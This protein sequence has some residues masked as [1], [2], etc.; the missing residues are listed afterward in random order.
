M[1]SSLGQAT[2][3]LHATWHGQKIEKKNGKKSRKIRGKI[4]EEKGRI[5][6]GL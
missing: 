3:I 1:G 6:L 4:E 5:Y 2:K